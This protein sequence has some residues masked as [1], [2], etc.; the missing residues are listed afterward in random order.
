MTDLPD[1]DLLVTAVDNP[2]QIAPP[3][4]NEVHAVCVVT[5]LDKRG[6]TL[7]SSNVYE[8]TI[9]KDDRVLMKEV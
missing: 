9:H 4:H 5:L 3:A 2:D 7:Y 1:M 6:K 8:G